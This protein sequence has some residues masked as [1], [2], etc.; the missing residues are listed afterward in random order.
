MENRDNKIPET[1]LCAG[2]NWLIQI[3]KLLPCLGIGSKSFNTEDLNKIIVK[4]LSLKAMLKYVGDGSGDLD[5]ITDI[6][7]LM[8]RIDSKLS[9]TRE[10]AALEQQQNKIKSR[11]QQSFQSED[12]TKSTNGDSKSKGEL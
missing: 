1:G 11:K 6:L 12:K 9:L 4:S 8:S 3:N 2:T 7:D 5:N 10:V